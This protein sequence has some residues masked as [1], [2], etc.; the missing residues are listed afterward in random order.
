MSTTTAVQPLTLRHHPDVSLAIERAVARAID[1]TTGEL[2]D[3]ENAHELAVDESEAKL[4][5]DADVHGKLRKALNK[6]LDQAFDHMTD[7]DSDVHSVNLVAFE[8][9]DRAGEVLGYGVWGGAPGDIGNARLQIF[10]ADGFK[11]GQQD[12]A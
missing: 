9:T 7:Q 8:V 5:P 1:L 3:A 10:D 2:N 12:E 11:L 4:G 6:A